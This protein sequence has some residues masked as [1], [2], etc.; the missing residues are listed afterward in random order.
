[1]TSA[2]LPSPSSPL[3]RPPSRSFSNPGGVPNTSNPA[4]N[5]P[6]RP[7]GLSNRQPSYN[8]IKA[9]LASTST[10]SPGLTAHTSP[11]YFASDPAGEEANTTSS[12]EMSAGVGGNGRAGRKRSSSIVSVQEVQETYDETLDREALVNSRSS[13]CFCSV[14]S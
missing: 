12:N 6:T 1:M 2:V 8:S 5:V 14:T 13:C 10:L 7:R 3:L 11:S 4:A 9:Q